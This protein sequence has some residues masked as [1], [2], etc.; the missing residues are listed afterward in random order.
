M[1]DQIFGENN[2]V[3]DIIW[4]RQSAHNDAKQGS[5]HLGRVH[6]SLLF[7]YTTG[8]DYV[9]HHLYGPYD[10]E[11]VAKAYRHFEPETG[12]RYRL[13]D[14]T[15]PG[16]GAPSKGNPHY[17]FLGVT[18]YWR[19]SKENMEQLYRQG[20]IIQTKPGTVPTQTL[21][22]RGKRG[23]GWFGVG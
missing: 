8:G 11:Y 9:F 13:G 12:R 1:L 5:K 16:A 7:L 22:R 19:Y 20:R 10:E 17:E 14:I 6:D 3:N 2:F 4:K 23:P 18:R 15:A 21:S